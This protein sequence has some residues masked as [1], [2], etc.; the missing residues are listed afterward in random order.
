MARIGNERIWVS[1]QIVNNNSFPINRMMFY[2]RDG[3]SNASICTQTSTYIDSQTFVGYLRFNQGGAIIFY[4]S[5][6]T[7]YAIPFPPT[8]V[9]IPQLQSVIS[10]DTYLASLGISVSISYLLYLGLNIVDFECFSQYDSKYV[11]EVKAQNFNPPQTFYNNALNTIAFNQQAPYN[12]IALNGMENFENSLPNDPVLCFNAFLFG[13]ILNVTKPVPYIQQ[14][15]FGEFSTYALSPKA[16]V[17]QFKPITKIIDKTVY[18]DGNS[19]FPITVSPNTQVQMW[20]DMCK[21]EIY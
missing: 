1:F 17:Y 6:N 16:D 18:L 13:Q 12:I 11:T 7:T 10:Q 2:L 19:G 5:D 4:F 21:Y 8:D 15:I 3:Y 14:N 20:S 9:Y